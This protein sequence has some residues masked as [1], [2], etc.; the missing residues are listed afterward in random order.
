MVHP[1]S[2]AP[3]HN[4]LFVLIFCSLAKK[5]E[6]KYD[7]SKLKKK[8]IN[9]SSKIKLWPRSVEERKFSHLI[10]SPPIKT[11]EAKF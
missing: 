6:T 4:H 9:E 11:V 5:G 7:G 3:L 2:H 10:T 1:F 8:N